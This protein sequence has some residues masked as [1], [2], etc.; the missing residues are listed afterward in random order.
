MSET[1]P[2]VTV[3]DTEK[4]EKYRINSDGSAMTDFEPISEVE[5]IRSQE[6]CS[7]IAS[8]FH[9]AFADFHGCKFEVQQNGEPTISLFFAHADHSN[10]SKPCACTLT[11][12]RTGSNNDVIQRARRRDTLMK[13]GDRYY[14]TEDG[15]DVITDLLI[16]KF[17]KNNGNVDWRTVVGEY[18]DQNNQNM[19]YGKPAIQYTKVSFIDPR[20][21]C[22]L[23][24]GAKDNDDNFDYG[25]QILCPLDNR[26]NQFQMMGAPTSMNYMLKIE[27]AHSKALNEVYN[28]IGIAQ[29]SNIITQ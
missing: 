20:L 24:Y 6:L 26:I 15:K 28:K 29:G 3:D 5:Y 18:S 17:I 22:K 27:R 11:N 23:I 19:W 8:V 14:L 21:I 12:I 25:V 13:D 1:N 2:N 9:Q 4:R 16:R 7:M 10:D